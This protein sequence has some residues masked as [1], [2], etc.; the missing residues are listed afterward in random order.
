MEPP[1]MINAGELVLKR[2]EP[3]W[4]PEALVAIKESLPE[5][6][7]FLPW[8]TEAYNLDDAVDYITRSQEGW[9]EGDQF[10][11]AIF[12]SV[13]ELVGSIGLMTR[14]GPGVLEIGYWMRTPYA[15]RGFMTAAVDALTRVALTL[16]GI[17][18]VAIKH[19]EANRA[20]AAVAVKAGFT[21][22]SRAPREVEAPGESG[23]TIVRERQ[24]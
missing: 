2:W 14:M 17:D 12:T 19:D 9:A 16:P 21:E 15:G 13:G 5:L 23:T 24:H 8:A 3:A 11:Y 6:R 22:V 18:R 1:E 10:N 20:S 4:A 7:E